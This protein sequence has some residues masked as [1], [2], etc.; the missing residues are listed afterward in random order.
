MQEGPP[1]TQ[2]SPNDELVHSAGPGSARMRPPCS[3]SCS[4]SCSGV[5]SLF[6]GP[7]DPSLRQLH[8]EGCGVLRLES[9]LWVEQ[10]PAVALER[11]PVVAPK[12]P[13]FGGDSGRESVARI[14]VHVRVV[15]P[16]ALQAVRRDSPAHE[17]SSTSFR[18]SCRADVK[19]SSATT[20]RSVHHW[21]AAQQASTRDLGGATPRS[22]ATKGVARP[23]H[24]AA[25]G[26]LYGVPALSR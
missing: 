9:G 24:R 23:W 25:H 22:G 12:L 10:Q 8:S 14:L 1:R 17:R 21:A 16:G 15:E 13:D 18:G 20:E 19:S 7:S 6:G 26:P 2:G 11:L 4:Y 3:Y 5:N